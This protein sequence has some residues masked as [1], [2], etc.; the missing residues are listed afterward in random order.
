MPAGPS[1]A[2]PKG[3]WRGWSLRI[4]VHEISW[5]MGFF[6]K[7]YT[8]EVKNEYVQMKNTGHY[9]K[10][11]V[12]YIWLNFFYSVVWSFNNYGIANRNSSCHLGIV[13]KSN[14]RRSAHYSETFF[15]QLYARWIRSRCLGPGSKTSKHPE[16]PLD[17]FFSKP[18]NLVLLFNFFLRLNA[19]A[20]MVLK[21]GA[22][23]TQEIKYLRLVVR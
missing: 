19:V 1:V 22:C 20:L 3:D 2:H 6:Q 13:A 7:H 9:R 16:K 18:S 17:F 21:I 11:A 10:S 12:G 14:I 5:V 4:K 23:T 15:Q 8:N